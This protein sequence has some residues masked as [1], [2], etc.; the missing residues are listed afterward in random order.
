VTTTIVRRRRAL[1]LGALVLAAAVGCAGSGGRAEEDPGPGGVL[2][3]VVGAHSNAPDPELT[4]AAAA[5]RDLAVAQQSYFSLVVADG[6]PYQTGGSGPLVADGSTST[7]RAEQHEAG[8]RHVDDMVE[9]AVAMTPE[10]DL[11]TAM[12]LVVQTLQ[13]EP[14]LHTL[15][16]VDSGLSTT[17]P[18]DFRRPGLL[19]ADPVEVA[20]SMGDAGTLP[21]LRGF[22]VVFQ[23]LGVTSA[24]Q[25]ELDPARRV[26]LVEIWKA[27]VERAGAVAVKVEPGSPGDPDPGLPVVTPVPVDPGVACT[28]G[29]VTLT[30]GPLGFQ[31]GEPF[32]SDRRAATEALRPYA[33]QMVADGNVIAEVFGTYAD[34]GDPAVRQSLSELRAQEVAY[35]LI[36]LGVP[37]QQLHVLGL[38]SDFPGFVPDRDASG[39]FDPA[40]VARNRTVILQLTEPLPCP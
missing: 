12:D 37:I 9:Q 20:D 32:L 39:R 25:Q 24:P 33:E 1:A 3:V 2:A 30:G 36:D 13:G 26:R 40:A 6:A 4:G 16:V 21:D 31:P 14:G 18:L 7:A 8:R 23:G 19:D 38:G 10:T 15:V 17:G 5:A 27:V 29:R 35:V 11:I 22:S 28:P 34:V